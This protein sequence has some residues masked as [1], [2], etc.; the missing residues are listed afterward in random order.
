MKPFH[1]IAI[2][3]KDILEGRLTLEV[4]AADLWE[5][6]QGRAPDEYKDREMF[7]RK[8]YLTQGLRSLIDIVERR[9][10]GKGGDP[11]IQIQTPFGGG[12]THSL[13]AMYHQSDDWHVK[14]VILVGTTLSP[15]ETLWGQ[16]EKQLTGEIVRFKDQIAP[17]REAIRQLLHEH[18]P[19]LILMDE[20]LEYVARVAG[21]N[22]GE[23]T[24]ATQTIAFIQELTETTS[25]LEKVCLVLSLPAS[26]IEHYDEKAEKLFQQLQKVSGRV[27]K[28]YTPVQENE[29]TQ[30]IRR[31]LFSHI[32]EMDAKNIINRFIEYSEKEGILP[33]DVL[34][35][36]YRDRFVASYPFLPEVVDVLYH[37]WGSFPT[38]QRTRGVLRL[39]A[40]VIHALKASNLFYISLADFDMNHQEIRQELL[41]H[42]GP[43]F[44]SII[45]ADITDAEAGAK[46][47]NA[48][49]A[50][51]QGLNLATR[52]ATTIFLYS[53]SGGQEV[54]ATL[55]EIK[56][57][58]T[59]I[60]N[61]PSLIAEIADQ[62]KGKLFYMQQIGD[63]YLFTNQ[64]NLNRILLT[65]MENVRQHELIK[66]EKEFLNKNITGKHFK[67]FIWEEN[68]S[69]IPDNEAL[70]LVILKSENKELMNQISKTK[71]QTPRIYR[72][73]LF[74]LCPME[75][76][77]FR[78]MN[79]MKKKIAYEAIDKDQNLKLSDEQKKDVKNSLKN[80]EGELK[81]NI[82]KLYRMIGRPDK[83]GV[84]ITDLGI[85]TYGEEKSLDDELYE[86]LRLDGAIIEKIAPFTLKQL[87]L[88]NNDYI[89]T[90][91]LYESSLKT[92]CQPIPLNKEIFEKSII[93]GVSNG[94]FGLGILENNQPICKFFKQV[95][96]ITFTENEVIINERLCHQDK[97][98]DDQEKPYPEPR[99]Q[100]ST[101]IRNGKS[102][103]LDE[104]T[105]DT[106][107]LNL[108]VPKGKVS[109]ITKIIT[110]LHTKFEMVNIVINATK[111]SITEQEYD[112]K[113]K[114]TLRQIGIDVTF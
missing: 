48:F 7:F 39:L 93:E 9:V 56:R 31:R 49:G 55:G 16:I 100:G 18:E 88:M 47:L 20:V 54:G 61:P 62:L 60:L 6:C 2:P 89:H 17:G 97:P 30:I 57:S 98:D 69:H 52:T 29:I 42:I 94:Y 44:N 109:D 33:S 101:E 81:E 64:P 95:P 105:K 28:I 78:V 102:Q 91:M 112:D 19:V 86:K 110:L 10:K 74:F 75:S 15:K 82:R 51:Y 1:T 85:P 96:L 70:K 66:L 46:K 63:K 108:V 11:V 79:I 111:G 37:R 32:H 13:I 83:D 40:I 99:P 113:I 36:A 76:E 92:P 59:T 103:K 27:E 12:K 106:V 90:A 71:G 26:L 114:E 8:T 38:F 107:S 72:N 35:S 68:P 4:F 80:T 53:F 41:K 50:A 67:V 34:P 25:I 84:K 65:K 77:R 43:E 21:V 24:L 45:A 58:A 73:T 23:S 104:K 5:V 3:H 87:Y 22:V 14:K